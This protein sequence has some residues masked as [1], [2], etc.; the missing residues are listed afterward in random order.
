MEAIA[1]IQVRNHVAPHNSYNEDGEEIRPLR[2][3]GRGFGGQ[4]VIGNG[5]S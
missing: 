5:T 2:D 1:V 4:S 3:R